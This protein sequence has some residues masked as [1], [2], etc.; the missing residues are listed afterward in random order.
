MEKGDAAAHGNAMQLQVHLRRDGSRGLDGWRGARKVCLSIC[1]LH[2]CGG[3][4]L[5]DRDC[6]K[7]S[8]WKMEKLAKEARPNSN[9]MAGLAGSGT[10]VESNNR[11]KS[12]VQSSAPGMARTQLRKMAQ[13]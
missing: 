2:T 8:R 9:Y 1:G 13:A 6:C 3:L 4:R 7:A 10:K 5:A 11:W 12:G